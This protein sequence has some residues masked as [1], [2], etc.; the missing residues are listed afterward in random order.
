LERLWDVKLQNSSSGTIP[1]LVLLLMLVVLVVVV[2]VGERYS[3]C[4][5]LSRLASYSLVVWRDVG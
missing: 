1:I 4:C 2:V 3:Q 5:S